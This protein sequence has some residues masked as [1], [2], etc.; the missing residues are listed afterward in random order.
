MTNSDSANRNDIIPGSIPKDF[1][2]ENYIPHRKT[3]LLLS[4]FT[5]LKVSVQGDPNLTVGMTINLNIYS[6]VINGDTRELDKFYSGKYLIN[7][8]RHVLQPSNGMYQT[9]MELAKDSYL[10][11]LESGGTN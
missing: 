7:A 5:L 4:N 3:Q 10:E 11:Q 6:L 2:V 8:V 9:Y 1:T